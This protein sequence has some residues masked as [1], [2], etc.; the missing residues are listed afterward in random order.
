[1]AFIPDQY[2]TNLALFGQTVIKVHPT[3][4]AWNELSHLFYTLYSF[5][6]REPYCPE[7][8]EPLVQA[9]VN[10]TLGLSEV[11]H[12]ASTSTE[13]LFERFLELLTTH[14]GKQP[15]TYY[16]SALCVT[17]QY[18]SRIV[19]LTSG[20]TVTEWI[21]KAVILDAR[22]LL[23]GTTQSISKISDTLHFPN[24]SFFCRFF[25]RETGYTPI[26]YRKAK[27]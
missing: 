11:A 10:Y 9:L 6:K 26:Q 23:R 15:V 4:E 27:R 24:D 22:I 1:M 2:P 3:P 8:V 19:S 13:H 12:L 7:V 21:N 17:P 5:A 18:L 14:K 25:K 16:A 20:K